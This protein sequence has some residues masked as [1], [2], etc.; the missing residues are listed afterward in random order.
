MSK[1]TKVEYKAKVVI[2]SDDGK[3]WFITRMD[4]VTSNVNPETNRC[5]RFGK[6]E[7]ID[8]E[9]AGIK[10]GTELIVKR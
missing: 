6:H 3:S 4:Y 1:R 8:A 2:E 9:D 7:F 10:T 5:F